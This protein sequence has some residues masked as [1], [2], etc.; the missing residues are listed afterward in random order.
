MPNPLN[1]AP[2]SISDTSGKAFAKT[3]NYPR[4]FPALATH[5][6][7]AL[8]FSSELKHTRTIFTSRPD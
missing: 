8:H 2:L 3:T 1:P 5:S 6:L 7:N 4:T